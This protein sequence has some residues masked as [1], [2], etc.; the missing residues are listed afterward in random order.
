MRFLYKDIKILY[1]SLK[2]SKHCTLNAQAKS[3]I[4]GQRHFNFKQSTLI[5]TKFAALSCLFMFQAY[6][7]CHDDAVEKEMQTDVIEMFTKWT[8]YPPDDFKGFGGTFFNKVYCCQLNFL[9]SSFHHFYQKVMRVEKGMIYKTVLSHHIRSTALDYH[10]F[11][12]KLDRQVCW[13]DS[14]L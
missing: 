2:Y 8:Q 4:W 12:S 10:T 5:S 14:L 9:L 1:F 11:Y 13:V 6:V 7:Q 3:Q